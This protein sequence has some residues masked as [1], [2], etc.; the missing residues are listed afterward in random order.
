M[1]FP[2]GG[3]LDHASWSTQSALA[4]L[5]STVTHQWMVLMPKAGC[6][7]AEVQNLHPTF[8]QRWCTLVVR[9]LSWKLYVDSIAY[10]CILLE[11]LSYGEK[12]RFVFWLPQKWFF[13][14]TVFTSHHRFVVHSPSQWPLTPPCHAQNA[15]APF[16]LT[17][18]CVCVR[19]KFLIS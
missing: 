16:P 12:P 14:S 6:Y 17:C 18:V 13:Q 1:L 10:D 5:R 11:L 19:E 8:S 15:L 7:G 4:Y 3:Y 9:P 2:Q